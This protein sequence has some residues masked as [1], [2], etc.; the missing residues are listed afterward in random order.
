HL[1][2]YTAAGIAPVGDLTVAS[3]A[4]DQYPN[5]AMDNGGTTVLVWQ[6]LGANWDVMGARYNFLWNFPTWGPLALGSTGDAQTHPVVAV[7]RATTNFVV[8]FQD[9][10]L[11]SVI[12]A[13]FNGATGGLT[14]GTWN[15]GAQ[16]DQPAVSIDGAGYWMLTFTLTGADKDIY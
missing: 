7:N 9:D 4:L 16:R 10:T 15:L 6:H 12:V 11:N 1:I 14:G 3:G 2:Q 13:E 8:A 5:V